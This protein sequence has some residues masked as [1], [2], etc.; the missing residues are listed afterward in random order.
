MNLKQFNELVTADYNRIPLLRE[1]NA[2]LDTPLS[3][4]LKLASESNTYLFESM[5]GGEKWGRYSLIGLSTNNLLKLTGDHLQIIA[6]G[7]VQ[8]DLKSSDPLGEIQKFK[9]SFRV[10]D[11]PNMP[12]FT[13]GLVGYFGYDSVRYVEKKLATSTPPDQM[14]I[15]DVMLLVSEELIIFDNLAGTITLVVHADPSVPDAFNPVSY[16]H[17]TLPTNVAV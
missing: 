2:D 17:L 15:P 8:T 5:Q 9:D 13:G 10:P 11:L 14:N 1:M 4:Y 16:T 3:I 7:H 12:R 6:D